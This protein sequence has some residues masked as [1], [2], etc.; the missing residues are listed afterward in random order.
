M[1]K[2]FSTGMKM[3]KTKSLALAIGLNFLLPGAGYLYYGKWFVGLLGCA[4]IIAMYSFNS[5]IGILIAW[6]VMNAV[7]LLDMF[8]LHGKSKRKAEQALMTF[9]NSC[10]EAI[11][12]EAKK[13]KHCGETQTIV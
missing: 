12:K 8:I 2:R 1:E 13:C 5:G 6:I 9:C 11:R 10:A 4:L 3:E 7:M